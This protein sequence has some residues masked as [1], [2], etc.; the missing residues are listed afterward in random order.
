MAYK[1]KIPRI[2]CD[3]NGFIIDLEEYSGDSTVDLMFS[4]EILDISEKG[5]RIKTSVRLSPKSNICLLVIYEGRK[6]LSF[7]QVR[8]RRQMDLHHIYGLY[9]KEW[10]YLDERLAKLFSMSLLTRQFFKLNEWMKRSKHLRT[11]FREAA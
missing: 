4:T 9:F 5:M 3:F 6:S 10:S 2:P 1:R 11:G 7:C 8:W